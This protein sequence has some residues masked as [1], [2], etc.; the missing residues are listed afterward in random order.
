M[1]SDRQVPTPQQWYLLM[2]RCHTPEN[3]YFDPHCR[4]NLKY[5]K[6]LFSLYLVVSASS[7][8]LRKGDGKAIPVTGHGGP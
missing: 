1:S 6:S 8:V 3:C 2:T 7:S 4:E 5:F